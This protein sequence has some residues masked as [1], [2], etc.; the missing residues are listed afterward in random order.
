MR[1]IRKGCFETNSSSMHSLIIKKKDDYMTSEELSEELR[2]IPKRYEDKPYPLR[3][4]LSEDEVTF[5]RYPFRVLRGFEDK[6]RYYIASMCHDAKDYSE[7]EK[8]VSDIIPN[9]N[10]IST[11]GSYDYGEDEYFPYGYAQNYGGFEAALKELGISLKEFLTNKKYIVIVDGDEYQ[12]FEKLMDSGVINSKEIAVQY[13]WPDGG[14]EKKTFDK[15]GNVIE[16]A[17]SWDAIIEQLTNR[18]E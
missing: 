4:Y 8:E 10:G 9:C 16:Y 14:W 7:I 15:Y 1:Q 2:P 17:N 6:L 18:G 3:L 13:T 11:W 12:E 5:E